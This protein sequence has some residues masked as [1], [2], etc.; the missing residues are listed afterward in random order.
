MEWAL[1]GTGIIQDFP[2]EK[3]SVIATKKL[4]E[5]RC[6]CNE[7][8]CSSENP[9]VNPGE[10]KGLEQHFAFLIL[11]ARSATLVGNITG[12]CLNQKPGWFV[13][14]LCQVEKLRW[15]GGRAG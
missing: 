14:T 15:A 13:T 3:P 6:Q 8:K 7:G 1:N 5:Q 12:S 2:K 10:V 4:F 9:C 11:S